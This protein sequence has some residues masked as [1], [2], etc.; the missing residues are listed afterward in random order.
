MTSRPSPFR[1]KI[2][3]PLHL[4]GEKISESSFEDYL[5]IY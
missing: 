2:M 5:S 3:L 4:E 1:D